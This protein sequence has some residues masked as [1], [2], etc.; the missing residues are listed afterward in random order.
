MKEDP[1]WIWPETSGAIPNELELLLNCNILQMIFWL[2]GILR[3]AMERIDLIA[4]WNNAW[5]SYHQE[6][7][8]YTIGEEEEKEE[9]E[10]EEEGEWNELKWEKAKYLE[11]L[12]YSFSD[13]FTVPNI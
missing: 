1:N 9:E 12:C 3:N 4:R 2:Y 6:R 13:Q 5:R 10:E 8:E 7:R 11:T